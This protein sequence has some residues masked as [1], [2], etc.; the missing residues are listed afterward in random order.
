GVPLALGAMPFIGADGAV[1]LAVSLG[2]LA[3]ASFST[4]TRTRWVT[5]LLAGL[6]AFGAYRLPP[7]LELQLSPYKPLSLAQL[8]PAARSALTRWSPSAR[9]DVIEEAGTHVY[10]GIS[11]NADLDLPQQTA[12]FIDGD[13]PLPITAA[14]PGSAE[15]QA[16]ASY[17]PASL[18]YELRP[19]GR[20]LVVQ[21]GAGLEALVALGSGAAQ[22][23]ITQDEP[24][25]L[26]AVAG[27]FAETSGRLLADPRITV[28]TRP[29]RGG[30]LEGTGQYDIVDFALSDPFR[31][32]T[33]GAFSLREHYPLTVEAFSAG[34]NRLTP[35][36][37]LVITRWMGTPPSEAA[38]A[39]AT[40]LAAMSEQGIDEPGAQLLAFRGMRTVT[41]I[42]GRRPFSASELETARSFLERNAFDPIW[43]PD[44]REEELNRHNR[45]PSP[46]YHELF[47]RLMTSFE[48]TIRDYDFNLRPPTDDRP[49]FFHYFRWRQTPE[50]LASLGL[51]WQPFGGSGY[52]VLVALLAL[53]TVLAAVLIL[54]PRFSTIR[55][56]RLSRSGIAYFA[57]L[58]A[59]YLLVE[60]PLI[61]RLTLLLDRPALALGVV[62][63]SLL[64]ASG[65][66]SRLST[67]MPLR[68]T[69]AVLVVLLA[70]PVAILPTLVQIGLPWS[71]PAW[72]SLAIV[73]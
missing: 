54:V 71:L 56:G 33:S 66:G 46:V 20:T 61:Q 42:A 53:V 51:I 40:L 24:L 70:L 35:D 30:L 4:W 34:L 49:Y 29:T 57:A 58:G 45:L 68:A 1:L 50:V 22:V 17:M 25:A 14:A 43:L 48:D 64:L 38:R 72:L 36:G 3:A 13:G 67:R 73:P 11:L 7:A 31:P 16:L 2:L 27:P 52:L 39:W 8:A 62:L 55:G 69:L 21:P 47:T 10:P 9:L 19:G 63:S 59:G 6:S 32:V 65:L 18:A 44:L 41:M 37:L 26:A 60:I 23:H 28:L 12:V 15:A 5:L